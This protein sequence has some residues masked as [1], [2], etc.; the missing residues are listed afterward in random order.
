[1]KKILTG[2][3]IFF[4]VVAVLV[5]NPFTTINAGQRGVLL[6]WGAFEGTVF[7][8]GLHIVIPIMNQVVKMNVQTNK[9]TIE[10]SE[11]YSKDLQ[12]VN[13]E[14]ALLYQLD[15][16]EVGTIYQDIGTTIE[17]KVIRP[18]LEAAIK[19]TIA[20]YTAEEILAQRA[21]VQAEI[22]AAVRISVAQS[23]IIVTQYAMVNEAFSPA[24]EAAIERKQVAEQDAKRAENE[25]KTAKIQ[26]EQRVAQAQAEATAIKLQSDAANN[27]KYISLRALEVQLEAVRKWDGKLPDTMI[28]GTTLPFV[29]I[30][31][32]KP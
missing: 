19:Q 14:S 32:V 2:L 23:H 9:L 15:A 22:E 24:F 12:V 29:N 11:S 10:G 21:V 3:L 26:A 18:S 31:T 16:K 27:E 17:E 8:P 1:M 4:A 7:E 30:P 13:I 25:L 20:K 28:P 6:R 5:I